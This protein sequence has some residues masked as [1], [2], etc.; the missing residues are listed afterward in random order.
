VQIDVHTSETKLVVKRRSSRDALLALNSAFDA[1]SR[2]LENLGLGGTP[3]AQAREGRVV[4]R[5][6]G[7]HWVAADERQ[8]FGPYATR[9]DA[10]ASMGEAYE[11]D[12]GA[13]AGESLR[14]AESE[15]GIADWID[16]ETGAPAEG[17]CPPHLE[18]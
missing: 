12:E 5:P 13:E 1:M 7:F 17:P 18:Q 15:L 9:E 14:E 11:D 10:L 8:E 2:R 4:E 3:E 16:P 6:D